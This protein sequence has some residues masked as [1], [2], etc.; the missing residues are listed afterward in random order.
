M[1]DQEL[2]NTADRF[3]V[4]LTSVRRRTLDSGAVGIIDLECW[5]QNSE[6]HLGK[7]RDISPN[8]PTS[9]VVMTSFP[10]SPSGYLSFSGWLNVWVT[11]VTD[12]IVDLLHWPMRNRRERRLAVVG[13]VTI[14]LPR[15]PEVRW[16]L[17]GH[18]GRSKR[19]RREN[20]VRKNDL[21]INWL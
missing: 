20:V 4:S 10:F 1:T 16:P 17:D 21:S 2:I 15:L 12:D 19:L 9:C 14:N 7:K 6:N 18:G 8:D 5:V 13:E 11:W 3:Y